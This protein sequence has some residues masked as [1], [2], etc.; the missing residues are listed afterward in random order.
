MKV[1]VIS[2]IHDKKETLLKVLNQS[3]DL[4][5]SA[6]IFCG[7]TSSPETFS[8]LLADSRP[9]YAVFGNIEYDMENI[10]KFT[11]SAKHISF[12][13]DIL[14]F[15][16]DNRNI[17]ISHYPEK[18]EIFAKS[19]IYDAVFHGHTHKSRAE[20]LGKTLI[21]NPGEISGHITGKRSFGIY[22]TSDNR[23]QIIPIEI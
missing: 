17:V 12:D 6:I 16:L 19:G 7:D 22:D 20:Y 21:G 1:L 18:V 15:K 13:S 2:D 4:G 3:K 23:F 5:C 11:T 8:S 9:I 14:I 10:E